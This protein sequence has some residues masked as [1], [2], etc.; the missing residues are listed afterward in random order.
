MAKELCALLTPSVFQLPNNPGNTRVY[1]HPTLASQLVDNTPLMQTEQA[2]I[3]M[4]FAREKHYFMLMQNI[5]R[6]CF[7]ALDASVK[8]TFKVS[9]NL[10]IQGWHAGMQVIDILDQLST[11]YGQ[12]TLAIPLRP[13]TQCPAAPTLPPTLLKSSSAVSKNAPRRSSLAATPTRIHS[14]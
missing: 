6:A 2:T 10:A 7:T 8:N 3:D 12:P 9:N 1:A 13:T 14:L 5:E 4:C 11:I